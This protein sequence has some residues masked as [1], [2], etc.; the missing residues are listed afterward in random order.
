[1]LT[2]ILAIF[3]FPTKLGAQS[4]EVDVVIHLR[5]VDES[6]I[7]L[8]ALNQARLFKPIIE[9]HERLPHTRV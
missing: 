7:S 1:M 2:A 3:W 4:N 8:L 9:T 5:G 6:K